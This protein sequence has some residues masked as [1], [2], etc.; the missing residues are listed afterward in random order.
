MD[1]I[2][3][4]KLLFT[5]ALVGFSLNLIWENLH[6]VLYTNVNDIML[7]LPYYLI[8]TV[9]DTLTILVLFWIM[10]KINKNKFWVQCLNYKDALTLLVLA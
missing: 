10:G 9:G 2:K 8:P 6:A 4:S 1:N 7:L 5:I 3:Q